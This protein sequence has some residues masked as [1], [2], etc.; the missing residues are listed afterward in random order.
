LPDGSKS[1]QLYGAVRPIGRALKS[2]NKLETSKTLHHCEGASGN[3]EEQVRR[4]QN[5][6]SVSFE[7]RGSESHSGV[8]SSSKVAKDGIISM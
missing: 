3:I 2:N 8:T 6:L 4:H 1:A 5:I 7:R